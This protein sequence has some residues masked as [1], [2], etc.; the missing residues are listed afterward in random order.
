MIG[1]R[2]VT[3]GPAGWRAPGGL[4]QTGRVNITTIIAV[5]AGRDGKRSPAGGALPEAELAR[6]RRLAHELVCIRGLS[7][8]EAQAEMD[9]RGIHRS[10]G[11]VHADLKNFECRRCRAAR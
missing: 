9:I 11:S 2:Q 10:V 4:A 5:R 1:L 7:V 6:A 3:P 8:R